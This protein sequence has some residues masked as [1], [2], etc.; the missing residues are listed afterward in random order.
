[1]RKLL[2]YLLFL[3]IILLLSFSLIFKGINLK[4]Y[5]ITII[6]SALLG[7]GPH[8]LI[9]FIPIYLYEHLPGYPLLNTSYY[10]DWIVIAPLYSIII[11]IVLSKLSINKIEIKNVKIKFKL[12]V[13]QKV[14]KIR[15]PLMI[16]LVLLL[17]VLLIIPMITQNYYYDKGNGILDRGEYEYN[18]NSMSKQ[19][20]A[21]EER[22][23]GGV[24]FAPPG[25]EIYKMNTNDCNHVSFSYDN[26]K[27]FRELS[28]PSYGSTQ[29]NDTQLNCY[30]YNLLYGNLKI[31]TKINI[32][33]IMSYLD[34]KY[35]V[36]L[37]NMT[38]YGN[39]AFNYSNLH[40]NKFTGI[41][42]IV[43]SK[44]YEIYASLYSPISVLYSNKFSIDIGNLYSLTRL[45]A[46][47]YDINHVIQV[48]SKNLNYNNFRFYINNASS[49]EVQN[50]SY[51]NYLYLDSVNHETIYSAEYTIQNY[52]AH[53]PRY[54]WANGSRYYFPEVSQLATSPNNY[55]ITCSQ[56]N[57]LT[58]SVAT[59]NKYNMIFVQIYFSTVAPNTN[60]SI[61]ANNKLVETVN[62]HIENSSQDGFLLVP[63]NYFVNNT[64]T[65]TINSGNTNNGVV[66]DFWIDAIGNIYIVNSSKYIENK[67]IINNIINT[68]HINI[69]S[70][71]NASRM[72]SDLNYS[73]G[74][75]TLS[76]SGYSIKSTSFRFAM[77]NFPLYSNEKS[78]FHA[79][80]NDI[81]TI[82]IENQI[83][84]NIR[85]DFISYKYWSYGSIIQIVFFIMLLIIM[86]ILRH[87][88]P[89]Y[90]T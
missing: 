57:N 12:K 84:K 61:F 68:R 83:N 67:N 89:K 86:P 76:D 19:L 24:I 60:I 71:S 90:R 37:K 15:K 47:N 43:N 6:F 36:L 79:I 80:S 41:Q 30:F 7:S 31:N 50:L 74:N 11:L 14:N 78:N 54:E 49:I 34:M 46:N 25:P 32:G 53:F 18:Y 88:K 9:R 65:L 23:P 10:W 5:F 8:S 40:M 55:A 73:L 85:I 63:I 44:N 70:F 39:S 27:A 58:V 20:C 35:I 22:Q 28:V 3:C 4:I 33:L 62:P 42:M 13:F 1:M 48:Y 17:A 81:N 21:I 51:L 69:Y 2:L 26:Y 82:I 64:T 16:I 56:F 66:P 77:V 87:E 45:E 59:S 29:S 38:Q 75:V 72:N 52:S